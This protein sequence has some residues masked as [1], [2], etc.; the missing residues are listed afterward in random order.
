MTE[1]VIVGLP[2]E[3]MSTSG[4]MPGIGP[5]AC[6]GS[7]RFCADCRL[8]VLWILCLGACHPTYTIFSRHVSIRH[9]SPKDRESIYLRIRHFFNPTNDPTS[10]PHLA[11][12]SLPDLLAVK[13]Q[14][15]RHPGFSVYETLLITDRQLP[16]FPPASTP[17]PCHAR[18]RQQK[19][20][21]Y[22][23]LYVLLSEPRQAHTPIKSSLRTRASLMLFEA[24]T[25]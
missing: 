2:A 23:I 5:C 1:R 21:K 10:Q 6:P 15:I 3:S 11:I 17:V 14:R 8:N 19:H 24:R 12:R 22:P 16:R 7:W 9:G 18:S 4:P 20:I 13:D 25:P